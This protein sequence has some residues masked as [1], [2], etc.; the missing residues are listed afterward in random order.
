M[1]NFQNRFFAFV[2]N[3]FQKK[4]DQQIFTFL[5]FKISPILPKYFCDPEAPN[6][7]EVW[8]QLIKTASLVSKILREKTSMPIFDHQ[9][10]VEMRAHSYLGTKTII[11]IIKINVS[12]RPTVSTVNR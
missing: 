10:L 6:L 2:S 4:N 9:R 5:S 1:S 12:K 8:T 11:R 3:N 7:T